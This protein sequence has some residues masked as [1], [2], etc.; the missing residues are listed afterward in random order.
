LNGAG[1][2]VHV[3][4]HQG[5]G[6]EAVRDQVATAIAKI[7]KNAPSN[8]TFLIENSAGQNGKIGT[9]LEETRWLIDQVKSPQLGWCLDTCHAWAAGYSL[10]AGYIPS[11][12]LASKHAHRAD[13][14]DEIDRLHLFD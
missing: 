7:L 11:D 1:V 12:E 2:V 8:S 6:W 10:S 5:R 14:L 4:S 9:N 13:I 3:G